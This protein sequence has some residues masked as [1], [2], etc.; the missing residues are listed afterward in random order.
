MISLGASAANVSRSV[1]FNRLTFD[2][3]WDGFT[4]DTKSPNR[5]VGTLNKASYAD[6]AAGA[7][8][9]F[10]PNDNLYMR[11]GLPTSIAR[12]RHF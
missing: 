6:I 12:R 5:E 8:Y 11:L 2:A 9:A 7:S 1:D 4:F 3:Q 10:F